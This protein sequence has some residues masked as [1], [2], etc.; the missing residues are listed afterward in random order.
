M[1][2]VGLVPFHD[3]ICV[4][5]QVFACDLYGKGEH[6]RSHRT[7]SLLILVI[8]QTVSF[9]P[10]DVAAKAVA[11]MRDSPSQIL[12]LTHPSPVPWNSVIQRTA[13]IL[14]VPLVYYHDWVSRLESV[15]NDGD[16]SESSNALRLL[17]FFQKANLDGSSESPCV[18]SEI[19]GLPR[20]STKRSI[21]Y[22]PRLSEMRGIVG[23]VGK[24]LKYWNMP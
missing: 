10:L 21:E 6:H 4:E 9:V 19:M 5:R 1:E 23:E 3:T 7:V 18:S 12:H 17:D 2:L 13:D 15:G 8:R 14:S 16:S 20:L 22:L 24:W 11:D